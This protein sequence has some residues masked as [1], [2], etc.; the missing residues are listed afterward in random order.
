MKFLVFLWFAGQLHLL[1]QAV[2]V[3]G[4][5]TRAQP[6]E[7]LATLAGKV[8][9]AQGGTPAAEAT[10][11]LRSEAS[12]RASK[13][14]SVSGPDGAFFIHRV[15]PGTYSLIAEKRGFLPEHY[16]ARR[17]GGRGIRLTLPED[18]ELKDVI[19]KLTPQA[20]ISGKVTDEEGEPVDKMSVVLMRWGY[21]QSKR[22]LVPTG[23]GFVN[24]LGEYRIAN[25]SPGTYYIAARRHAT[26]TGFRVMLADAPLATGPETPDESY[27][28]TYYPSSISPE[29]AATLQVAPGAEIR[30]VDIRLRKARVFR[31]RGRVED[32]ATG[33][34][35]AEARVA[36][37]PEQPR[38]ILSMSSLGGRPIPGG[39]F[40]ISG[41]LP[42]S[43]DL[44]AQVDRGG[45]TL[46][47]RQFVTVTDRN[48][49]GIVVRI[50][51]PFDVHGRVRLYER[52]PQMAVPLVQQTFPLERLRLGLFPAERLGIGTP[53]ARVQVDGSFT[54]RGIVPD[55]FRFSLSGSP[56]GWYVKSILVGGRDCPDGVADLPGGDVE[57][58]LAMGAAELT[59]TVRNV[60]DKPAAGA[61]V[62]LA[63]AE[64]RRQG[65]WSLYR[66]T[67]A[68]QNGQFELRDLVPGSYKVFAWEDLDLEVAHDLELR[69]HF[70]SK[71]IAISLDENGRET[72]ELKAIP[73]EEV[74]KVLW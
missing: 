39:E 63:P 38:S 36:L 51:V 11:T 18:G 71:A 5:P 1:A 64:E 44:V 23:G 12:G 22:V 40:E 4:N 68:D 29:G 37:V 9:N 32:N 53:E 67:Q 42:G 30:G 52:D 57:V 21:S 56:P 7:R 61:V 43:Y 6:P 24:D 70:E 13:Y 46:S 66:A 48:V 16:G 20:I 31:V 58:V 73:T 19:L 28:T 62:A 49:A 33:Q 35:V 54:L 34:L 45:Q 3:A 8:L 17:P 47:A 72:A 74:A 50:P 65:R 2:P 14:V 25:I 26:T 27:Q 59:G 60:D 41:V 15:E 55:S 10:L 69:R